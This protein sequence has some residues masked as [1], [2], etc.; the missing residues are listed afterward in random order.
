MILLPKRRGK[1]EFVFVLTLV[2]NIRNRGGSM[3]AIILP[4]AIILTMTHRAV[5]SIM[6]KGS[7]LAKY[8]L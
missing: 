1:K 6:T 4:Q 7:M 2:T 5:V 3:K 8:C